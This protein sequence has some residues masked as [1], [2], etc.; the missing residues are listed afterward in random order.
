[1]KVKYLDEVLAL[2]LPRDQY[3]L[4][5][6]TCL[7]VHGLRENKDVDILVKERI[8]KELV[9]EYPLTK[10]GTIEIGNVEIGYSFY[11]PFL[12]APIDDMIDTAEIIDGLKYVKLEYVLAWKKRRMS[13]K[14]IKDIRLIED[15][16]KSD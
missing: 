3:A 10:R 8:W 6:S 1:M 13:E 9:K 2:N 14:D 4:F 11:N 15:Y 12:N 7:A 16:L 5:G